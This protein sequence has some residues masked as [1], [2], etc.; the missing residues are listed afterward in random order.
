MFDID[1][2]TGIMGIGVGYNNSQFGVVD[3]KTGFF[4]FQGQD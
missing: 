1:E 3:L 2:V 4:S